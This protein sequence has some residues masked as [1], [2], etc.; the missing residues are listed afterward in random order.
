M[1]YRARSPIVSEPAPLLPVTTLDGSEIHIH[2]DR[3]VKITP[4]D[5]QPATD[6]GPDPERGSTITVATGTGTFSIGVTEYLLNWGPAD[7]S[8]FLLVTDLQGVP[9]KIN[10]AYVILMRAHQPAGTVLEIHS[11]TGKEEIVVRD[12][13]ADV[14]DW[15]AVVA[16]RRLLDPG[17]HW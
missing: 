11:A 17:V 2:I 15:W 8:A 1:T 7:L 10:P 12:S 6:S 5:P 4:S 16:K 3:I 14:T 9:I 13:L